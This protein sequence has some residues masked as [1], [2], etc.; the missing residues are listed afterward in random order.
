MMRRGDVPQILAT[1]DHFDVLRRTDVSSTWR[2]HWDPWR[3]D[4]A[5]VDG[6]SGQV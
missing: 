3:R 2:G 4:E 6:S 5:Q 1:K